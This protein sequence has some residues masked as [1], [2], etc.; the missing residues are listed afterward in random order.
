MLQLKQGI[1]DQRVLERLIQL[2]EEPD[3]ADAL[4]EEAAEHAVLRPDMT[5]LGRDVLDDVVGRGAQN[6]FRDVGLLL[7]NAGRADILL[8]E[9]DRVRDLLHQARERGAQQC[10]AQASEQQQQRPCRAH[11]RVLVRAPRIH[12]AGAPGH[13]VCLP[14]SSAPSGSRSSPRSPA[15]D[16]V[17]LDTCEAGGAE[18]AGATGAVDRRAP[19]LGRMMVR[20]PRPGGPG[21]RSFSLIGDLPGW[22]TAQ[23]AIRANHPRSAFRSSWRC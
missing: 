7:R 12:R 8:E 22:P 5:I 15:D 1:V 4:A 10:D 21:G 3:T 2:L 11:D 17:G 20:S 9:L 19:G 23:A 16:R 18:A 6:V 13:A 14:R